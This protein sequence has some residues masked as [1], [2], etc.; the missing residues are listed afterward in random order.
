MK[1]LSVCVVLTGLLLAIH[2]ST[3]SPPPDPG[4]P[5]L[6]GNLPRQFRETGDL[7]RQL[8]DWEHEADLGRHYFDRVWTENGWSSDADQFARQVGRTVVEIPPWNLQGRLEKF[9]DLIQERYQLDERQRRVLA[10]AVQREL[11]GLTMRHAATILQQTREA[12]GARVRGEPF[13]A[14][15]IAKWTRDSE[16]L[17]ADA[18]RGVERIAERLGKHLTPDQQKLLAADMKSYDKRKAF[19]KRLRAEWADGRWK[20]EDWGLENDRVQRGTAGDGAPPRLRRGEN[21]PDPESRRAGNEPSP[22]VWPYDESTWARYATDFIARYGLD[23]SQKRAVQSILTE[24]VARAGEYRQ[25]HKAELDA[26]APLERATHKKLDPIRALFQ[27]LEQRLDTVPTG[28]QSRR[29]GTE[30]A[31]RPEQPLDPPPAD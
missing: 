26:I 20:A 5:A 2:R 22:G 19:Y 31:D 7:L 18:R 15:Q 1:R 12:V 27:E 16:P 6:G 9:G 11:I 3:A 28:A 21:V 8:G 4:E 25:A 14:D 23:P 29:A 17:M 30:P 24:L 13:T 10:G